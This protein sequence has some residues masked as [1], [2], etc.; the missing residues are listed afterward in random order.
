[1]VSAPAKRRAGSGSFNTKRAS[2]NPPSAAQD[3]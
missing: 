2:N 3:G 1:M